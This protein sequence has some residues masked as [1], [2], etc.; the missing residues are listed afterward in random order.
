LAN[1]ETKGN[2]HFRTIDIAFIAIFSA[3]YIVMNLT[4]GPLSFQLLGL[5][6]LHDFGIFFTLLLVAWITGRLGTSIAVAIIGSAIAI[7]LGAPPLI[8]GFAVSSIMFDIILIANHHKIRNSIKGLA[9]PVLATIISAY[10]A[11]VIIGILFMS[12]GI[13]WA[14]TIWGGWH[15]IGGILTIA[16]TLPIIAGLEKANV[17]K[18]AGK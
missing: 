16:I 5:P 8:I 9:V 11:G 13:Q 6:I 1:V 12:N 7:L 18:L 3:L 2:T 4:L 14:L 10:V 15:L 17:R